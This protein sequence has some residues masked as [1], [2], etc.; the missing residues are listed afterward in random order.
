M[1]EVDPRRGLHLSVLTNPHYRQCTNGP[2]RTCDEITLVGWIDRTHPHGHSRR[3]APMPLGSHLFLP[4]P[5][6]PP[7]ALVL[8]SMGDD[9]LLHL[10]PVTWDDEGLQYAQEPSWYMAGGNYASSTDSRIMQL[11]QDLLGH[12]FHGAFS[13]HDRR[14]W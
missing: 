10:E 13:V 3:V 2:T 11:A 5:A 14:E 1:A 6:A 12:R 7:F 4:G 9:N 8:R